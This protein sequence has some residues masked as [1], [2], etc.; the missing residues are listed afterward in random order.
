MHLKHT[1]ARQ[2]YLRPV[3]KRFLPFAIRFRDEASLQMSRS[4][5]PA[6]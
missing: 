6:N 3:V 2:C 4:R 5:T 1:P